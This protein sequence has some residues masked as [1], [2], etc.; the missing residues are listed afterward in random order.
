[1][2]GNILK[3]RIQK[4]KRLFFLFLF[5]L[6]NLFPEASSFTGYIFNLC[7]SFYPEDHSRAELA[8]EEL[9]VSVV[10]R[11]QISIE[12]CILW[13]M[14]VLTLRLASECVL[15]VPF[16]FRHVKCSSISAVAQGAA[17][18]SVSQ[19]ALG[20]GD[21]AGSEGIDGLHVQLKDNRTPH[22]GTRC[23]S[24]WESGVPV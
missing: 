11:P 20:K 3:R 7:S 12:K 13:F 18:E 21:R 23:K 10:K 8:W 15:W 16:I 2:G 19:E 4:P 24:D 5:F 22:T 9:C 14:G 1:M 6:F 17:F